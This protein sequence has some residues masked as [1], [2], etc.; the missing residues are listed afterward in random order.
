M[1]HKIERIKLHR[2]NFS[3]KHAIYVAGYMLGRHSQ[4][5]K[6]ANKSSTWMD[7]SGG[8]LKDGRL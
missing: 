4:S 6:Q 7:R 2:R 5:K 1:L 3:T 8:I